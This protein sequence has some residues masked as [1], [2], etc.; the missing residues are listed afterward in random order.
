M[1]GRSMDWPYAFRATFYVLPR[2]TAQEGR[3]GANSLNWTTKYGLV[4]IAGAAT[5]GGP[6]DSVFDGLNEKGL[7]A[8][9]ALSRRSGFRRSAN[10]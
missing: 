6:I 4:E 7:A 1:T 9:S 10:G 8:N 2:G 5:P 3:G